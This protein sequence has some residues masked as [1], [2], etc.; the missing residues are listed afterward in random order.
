M[1]IHSQQEVQDVRVTILIG[2]GTSLS[3]VDTAGHLANYR[4]YFHPLY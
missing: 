2:D 1:H 3:E 4:K